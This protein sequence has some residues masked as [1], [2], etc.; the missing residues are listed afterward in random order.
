MNRVTALLHVINDASRP[1]SERD[2]ALAA[3][4]NLTTDGADPAERQQAR[5]ALDSLEGGDPEDAPCPLENEVVVAY[6][7]ASLAEIPHHFLHEFISEHRGNADVDRLYQKWLRVSPVARQK[8]QQMR[9]HLENYFLAGYDIMLT[10]YRAALDGGG[11]INSAN[12]DALQFYRTWADSC[13]TPA[14]LKPH[15][16][17]L[18]A[19]LAARCEGHHDKEK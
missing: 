4:T 11:D 7:A 2:D 8:M 18:I 12:R 9:K 14:E 1:Q 10:R 19:A 3:L 6:H 15:S 17:Q 13:V 5:A 16:R